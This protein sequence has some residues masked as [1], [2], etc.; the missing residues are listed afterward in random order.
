MSRSDIKFRKKMIKDS[1]FKLSLNELRKNADTKKEIL[2][3]SLKKNL[4]NFM[5]L[6]INLSLNK[7]NLLTKRS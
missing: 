6:Q 1:K 5:T 2:R 7:R 3:L 4:N